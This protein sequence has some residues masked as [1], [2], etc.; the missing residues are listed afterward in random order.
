[1]TDNLEFLTASEIAAELKTVSDALLEYDDLTADTDKYW[2]L[3]ERQ[4][5][6]WAVQRRIG[7]PKGESEGLRS[8]RERMAGLD[9]KLASPDLRDEEREALVAERVTVNAR[10]VE[11]QA[12]E[13]FAS[14]NDAAIAA[15]VEKM[16]L[17][18]EDAEAAL[19]ALVKDRGPDSIR[20]KKAQEDLLLTRLRAAELESELERRGRDLSVDRH[21]E[22][23][24]REEAEQAVAISDRE[25]LATF[26]A[27]GAEEWEILKLQVK[28]ERS[29]EERVAERTAELKAKLLH[30]LEIGVG[31]KLAS[32]FGSAPR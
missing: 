26:K 20:V 28:L 32:H 4:A 6:L 7:T 3:S 15:N 29:R 31:E 13:K 24:A 14:M 10:G 25:H 18:V 22:R 30:E 12:A 21:Y 27:A 5:A 17:A 19:P 8:L 23:R 2:E 1:M 16:K 9:E 11:A